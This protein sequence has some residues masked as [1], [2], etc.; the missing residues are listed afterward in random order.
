L[1]TDANGKVINE[2]LR[3]ATNTLLLDMGGTLVR[4]EGNL[5]KVQALEIAA[6]LR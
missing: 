4:I 5:T 6:S 1:F 2:S 3:L